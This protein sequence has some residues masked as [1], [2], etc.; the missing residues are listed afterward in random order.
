MLFTKARVVPDKAADSTVSSLRSTLMTPSAWLKPIQEFKVWFRVPNGPLYRNIQT[1]NRYFSTFWYWYGDFPTLDIVLS[2]G[3]VAN[4]FAT[5]ASSARFAI[6]HHTLRR[7]NNCYSQTIHDFRNIVTAFI[8]PQSRRR[9]ALNA[10]NNGTASVILQ[11]DMQYRLR[12]FALDFKTIDI[13]PL[14]SGLWRW[15]L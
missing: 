3:D 2:L 12:S 5:H 8:D 6:G 13:A 9:Y 4:N 7:R 10:F 11:L 1:A 15:P 14:L